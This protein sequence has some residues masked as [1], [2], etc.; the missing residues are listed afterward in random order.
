MP[1]S[2]DRKL[3]VTFLTPTQWEKDDTRTSCAACKRPFSLFVRK[4]HCRLCGQ[5]FCNACSIRRVYA[6]RTCGDCYVTT[7]QMMKVK[8]QRAKEKWLQRAGKT[9]GKHLPK[10][11][12]TDSIKMSSP[13]SETRS[14]SRS[15]GTTSSNSFP[16][17]PWYSVFRFCCRADDVVHRFPSPTSKATPSS[18]PPQS[19]AAPSPGGAPR[20]PTDLLGF[21]LPKRG[22]VPKSISCTSLA[23]ICERSSEE[24]EEDEEDTTEDEVGGEETTTSIQDDAEEEDEEPEEDE[25]NLQELE[26]TALREARYCEEQLEKQNLAKE[27]MEIE[28]GLLSVETTSCELCQC[29]PQEEHILVARDWVV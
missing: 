12:S 18:S 22:S 13:E 2:P 28:S 8:R 15:T 6:K 3:R 9:D 1:Q 20:P 24:D 19:H 11:S 5:I 25:P 27:I 16:T 7:T 29:R 10:S 21:G 14:L 17:D 23:S 4:H 26:S